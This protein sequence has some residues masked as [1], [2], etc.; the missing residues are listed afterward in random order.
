MPPSATLSRWASALALFSLQAACDEDRPASPAVPDV[1]PYVPIGRPVDP[2]VDTPVDPLV[3]T[4]VA[5]PIS[6]FDMAPSRDAAPPDGPPPPTPLHLRFEPILLD[7]PSLRATDLVFLPDTRDELMILDKD[8]FIYHLRMDG[9]RATTISSRPVLDTWFDSDAGAIS[10]ALDPNFRDNRFFYVALTTSIERSVVRRYTF[11]VVDDGVDILEVVGP[12]APRSWHNI[13]SIGFDDTGALWGLFG[14]KV[15]WDVAHDPFSPLGALLRVLPSRVPGQGGHTF[16]DDNAYAPGEGHPAVFAKGL[17]S[18]WKGLFVNGVYYFGDVGL[19]TY[20]EVNRVDGPG[21]DF[22]W[23]AVEGPCREA[24]ADYEEP[25]LFYGRDGQHRFVRDDALA[26][27]SR[28]RSVY[29]GHAGVP[30]DQGD[31]PYEGRWSGVLTFGDM[32]VGFV[33]A[34]RLDGG[35]DWHVGHL[36]WATAW[37]RGGDGFVYVTTL[38]TWPQDNPGVTQ[39]RLV[40]A[41]LS[42]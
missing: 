30:R 12:R 14:D 29:V 28:L 41:V 7:A 35:P 36:H 23:P 11:G 42:D 10:L 3:D 5:P 4:P 37:A 18:P 39:S 13:G 25:W 16:P 24:C 22:G 9:D 31:D 34:R 6:R 38:G 33:R 8:G 19:E 27:S 1:S 2:L 40:R 21:L 15:L 26:T 17:R 32:S 20:E